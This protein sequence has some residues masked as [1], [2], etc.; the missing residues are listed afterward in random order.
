[1]QVILTIP[2]IIG[3]V[4]VIAGNMTMW[5]HWLVSAT[6]KPHRRRLS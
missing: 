4:I 1:M 5:I 2:E 6:M 3:G